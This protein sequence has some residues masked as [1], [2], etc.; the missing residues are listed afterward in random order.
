MCEK[1][2]FIFFINTEAYIL[3]A[4]DGS[5]TNMA[6]Y[7]VATRKSA[8][9]KPICI[10]TNIQSETTVKIFSFFQARH[11]K[12]EMIDRVNTQHIGP[13]HCRYHFI[14]LCIVVVN[15]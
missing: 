11:R 2:H 13:L 9:R 6:P 12:P 1:C 15:E 3:Q 8:K 14:F 10:F 4:L 5:F 7:M